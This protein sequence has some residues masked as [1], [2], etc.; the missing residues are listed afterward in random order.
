MP[1]AIKAIAPLV[2][3]PGKTQPMSEYQA[4]LHQV[5]NAPLTIVY[6]ACLEMHVSCLS[7]C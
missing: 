2:C 4:T 5:T 1:Q 7:V 6:T 3:Q